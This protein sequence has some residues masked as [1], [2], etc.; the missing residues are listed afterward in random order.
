MQT[1]DDRPWT[2]ELLLMIKSRISGGVRDEPWMLSAL[3]LVRLSS[4]PM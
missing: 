3:A 2:S 4:K 1:V